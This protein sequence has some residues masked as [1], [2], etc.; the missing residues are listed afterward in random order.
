MQVKD[1]EDLGVVVNTRL[2]ELLMSKETVIIFDLDGVLSLFEYGEFNHNP[3]VN[4]DWE[5]EAEFLYSNKARPSKVMQKFI[6]DKG[7]ENVYV[8]TVATH[9]TIEHKV[10]FVGRNYGIPESHVMYCEHTIDK[11][12]AVKRIH[13]EL[14]PYLCK[15]NV[16]VIEDVV[17]VLDRVQEYGYTT[18]HIS[19]FLE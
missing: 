15:R 8:L 3:K 2:M 5:K 1:R 14:Y 13:N 19:S 11:P 16:A 7:V 12:D 18:V 10:K 9:V 6:R 17:K 4:T